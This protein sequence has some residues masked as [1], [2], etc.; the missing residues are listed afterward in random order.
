MGDEATPSRDVQPMSEAEVRRHYA[1]RSE[2]QELLKPLSDELST[3]RGYHEGTKVT[4]TLLIPLVC[5]F[6]S[7]TAILIAALV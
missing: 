6:V 4:L 5:V 1:T 3:H 2:V 7:A